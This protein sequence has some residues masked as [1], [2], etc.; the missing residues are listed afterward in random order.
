MDYPESADH[1]SGGARVSRSRYWLMFFVILVASIVLIGLSIGAFAN[2]E[3]A[4]GIIAFLLIAPLNVYF[5]VI[6]MRR[7]RDIGW[8]PALPWITFGLG[9]VASILSL[10]SIATLDPAVVLGG[11]GFSMLVSLADL[12]LMVA[13]GSVRSKPQVDYRDV[14][15]GYDHQGAPQQRT[16]P[17][18]MAGSGTPQP[19]RVTNGATVAATGSTDAMDDAIARALENYKR[20][21]SAVPELATAGSSPVRQRSPQAAP[22]RVAGFGR[23][24]V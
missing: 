18:A 24:K 9:I 21:G 11:S 7:C 6:M 2:G 1:E 10:G 23:K 13:L 3:I 15:D 19:G 8:A 17:R 12:V 4:V 16:G 20:T 5:R 22:A 14:F